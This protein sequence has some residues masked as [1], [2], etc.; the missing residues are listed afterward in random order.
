[1]IFYTVLF[2][3]L[4]F[5]KLCLVLLYNCGRIF[6]ILSFFVLYILSFGLVRLRTFRLSVWEGAGIN[7][8]V[9]THVGGGDNHRYH[10]KNPREKNVKGDVNDVM[11]GSDRL[12]F[13]VILN[14]SC[15]LRFGLR[16]SE[17]IF[18]T[19]A[20]PVQFVDCGAR[21][22]WL[23]QWVESWRWTNS[24]HKKIVS[25]SPRVEKPKL[26]EGN[27]SFVPEPKESSVFRVFRIPILWTLW[28]FHVFVDYGYVIVCYI[29]LWLLRVLAICKGST[30]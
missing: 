13:L 15:E 21:A 23:G 20:R 10:N 19:W 5:N 11:P 9:H 12:G 14:K 30:I 18:R 25:L 7:A 16:R 29:G 24:Q 26:K 2:G 22:R 4:L 27:K 8:G 17:L 3:L 6:F 28:T 1:M